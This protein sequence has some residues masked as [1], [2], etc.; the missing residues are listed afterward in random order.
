MH[1]YVVIEAEY[2]ELWKKKLEDHLDEAKWFVTP[3]MGYD[4]DKKGQLCR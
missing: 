2:Q 3:V 4:Y 1:D